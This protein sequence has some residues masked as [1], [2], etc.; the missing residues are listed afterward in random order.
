M[1]DDVQFMIYGMLKVDIG[2]VFGHHTTVGASSCRYVPR[3]FR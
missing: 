2:K 1:E 3:S